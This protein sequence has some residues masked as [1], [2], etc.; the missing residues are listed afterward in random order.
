[1]ILLA[2]VCSDSLV[3]MVWFMSSCEAYLH[4]SP[5]KRSPCTPRKNT[6]Y[7]FAGQTLEALVIVISFALQTVRVRS[8]RLAMRE[9]E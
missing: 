9:K 7:P 8:L 3:D 6:W 2:H 1:M 4:T 5:G